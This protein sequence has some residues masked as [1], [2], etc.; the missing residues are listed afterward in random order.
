[1]IRECERCGEEFES[2]DPKHKTC[3]DCHFHPDKAVEKLLLEKYYD[4]KGNL[5]E[6]VYLGIPEK[7][8]KIFHFDKLTSTQG[9]LFYEKI[10]RAKEVTSYRKYEE[11]MPLLN[12][13]W[14]EIDDKINREVR[15]F[16]ASFA[17]FLKHHLSIAKKN[18]ENLKGFCEHFYAVLARISK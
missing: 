15:G 14:A 9:R 12:R 3:R 13:C 16:P 18:E 2:R 5:L 1:M 7:L 17:L 4:E 11:A 10:L 8:A 6:E